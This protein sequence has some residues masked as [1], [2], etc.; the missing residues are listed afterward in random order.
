MQRQ[1]QV[2]VQSYFIA[3]RFADGIEEVDIRTGAEEFFY[4]VGSWDGRRA[5]MDLT[6]E[7]IIQDHLPPFVFDKKDVCGEE[8]KLED[9]TSKKK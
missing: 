3:L 1:L 2:A 6:I 9:V 5:G 7:H 8:S 4:V